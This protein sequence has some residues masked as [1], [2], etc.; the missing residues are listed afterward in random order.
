VFMCPVLDGGLLTR[1]WALEASRQVA[2]EHYIRLSKLSDA[3]CKFLFGFRA[4]AR[5]ATRVLTLDTLRNLRNVACMSDAEA[6]DEEEDDGLLDLGLEQDDPPK[7]RRKSAPASASAQLA[8]DQPVQI[9]L[10]DWKFTVLHGRGHT[11]VWMHLTPENMDKL[12]AAVRKEV[13]DLEV[14][15]TSPTESSDTL[16]SEVSATSPATEESHPLTPEKSKQGV[17]T[18]SGLSW[19]ESQ[20]RWIVRF[21][22]GGT[23]A[24]KQKT[25]SAFKKAEPEAAKAEAEAAAREWIALRCGRCSMA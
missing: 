10:N 8:S 12:F 11:D 15:A 3:L 16:P 6:E 1:P 17:K 13:A 9:A 18:L 5:P 7:R 22:A 24:V 23:G 20:S 25:F 21:R 19:V 2:G 4:C 14:S